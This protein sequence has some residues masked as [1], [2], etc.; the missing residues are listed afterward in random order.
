MAADLLA[1]VRAEIDDRLAELRPAVAEYEQLLGAA[2]ALE[3]GTHAAAP[4]ARRAVAVRATAKPRKAATPRAAAK[5]RSAA[6]ARKAAKPRQAR[7]GAGELAIVAALEHGSHTVG[8]LGVVTAM[9]GAQI[10]ASV[11]RLLSTGKIARASRGG[12]VA[13]ALADSA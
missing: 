11:R 8:E 1:Q 4:S 7:I 12:R 2:G 3:S 13:Y 9:S 5:P 6:R 10:R